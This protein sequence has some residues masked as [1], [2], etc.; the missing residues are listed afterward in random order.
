MLS[1]N[2]N[3][4]AIQSINAL[5]RT[6]DI[7]SKLQNQLSTG[8]KINTAADDAAGISISTKMN[9]RISSMKVAKDN[10]AD[11]I[12]VTKIADGGLKGISETLQSIRTL[13]VKSKS[14]TN[15]TAER[16]AI[17]SS[18]DSLV[19]EVDSYVAQATFNGIALLDGTADLKIQSGADAGDTNSITISQNY[20]SSSLSV[21]SLD[22]SSTTN[23]G[24]A[25]AAVDAALA[26][27]DSGRTNIGALQTGF[28]SKSSFLGTVIENTASALSRIEDVD[29]A[30]VQAELIKKQAL[31]QA[32]IYALSSSLSTPT[33]ILSLLR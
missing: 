11:A 25:L 15:T 22:V 20:D 29:Y 3:I 28:E 7:I 32:N 2:S 9:V 6:Q 16:D 33:N 26:L 17:Q 13:I 12:S 31:Q 27:V 23:A 10:V 14:D 1:L 8:K 24:T 19:K 4:P 21:D 18:I 5:N 30:E